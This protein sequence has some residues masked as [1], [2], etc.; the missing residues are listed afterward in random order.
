MNYL[1]YILYTGYSEASKK[2]SDLVKA[3]AKF[4]VAGIIMYYLLILTLAF[5]III[6]R[7]FFS[8]LNGIALR[9]LMF[10]VVFGTII[11]TFSSIYIYYTKSRILTIENKYAGKATPKQA[12]IFYWTAIILALIIMMVILLTFT[13]AT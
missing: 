9:R 4:S 3:N 10:A 12:L 1:F 2:S 6:G 13:K 5:T 8:E 11:I 7:V